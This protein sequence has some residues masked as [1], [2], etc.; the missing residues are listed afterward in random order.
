MTRTPLFASA[1]GSLAALGLLMASPAD[2][3]PGKSG[4]PDIEPTAEMKE[5][6]ALKKQIAAEEL[7]FALA[8]SPEQSAQLVPLIQGVLTSRDD[9]KEARSEMA[10]NAKP[11]FDRYLADVQANGEASAAS[12]DAVKALRDQRKEGREGHKASREAIRDTLKAVLSPEQFE[13]LGSFRP[14]SAVGPDEERQEMRR[15]RRMKR[16]RRGDTF[17]EKHDIEPDDMD[18]MQDRQRRR[19][20][21]KKARQTVGKVLLSNEML[22]VLS[23]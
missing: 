22:I 8:L 9:A 1:L 18:A 23:R 6:R 5:V 10:A 11:V 13:T 3:R 17:A 2:A 4:P 7:A 21:K 16:D 12:V 14:M 19:A 20:G 15:E